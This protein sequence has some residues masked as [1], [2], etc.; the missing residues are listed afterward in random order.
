[1]DPEK[2]K[3]VELRTELSQRGLDTKGVKSVLVERLRKALQEEN[4]SQDEGKAN[5]FAENTHDVTSQENDERS[6]ESAKVPQTPKKSSRLSK[7]A[8]PVTP[9]ETPGAKKRRTSRVTYS[10]KRTSPKKSD[11]NDRSQP[12]LQEEP[13]IL[14]EGTGQEDIASQEEKSE[15]LERIK[16]AET[17]EPLQNVKNESSDAMKITKDEDETKDR[18]SK[19]GVAQVFNAKSPVKSNDKENLS[20]KKLEEKVDYKDQPQEPIQVAETEENLESTEVLSDNKLSETDI[21]K[22]DEPSTFKEEEN[23]MED[24]KEESLENDK[25]MVEAPD[26]VQIVEPVSDIKTSDIPQTQEPTDDLLEQEQN[27]D[28]NENDEAKPEDSSMEDQ[29]ILSGNE[30]AVDD[31]IDDKQNE[32][33]VEMTELKVEED[34]DVEL[35]EQ[36]K[37]EAIKDRKRKRS[38]S[39]MEDREDSPAV[40]LIENEPE[41]DDAALILSWYDSDLNLVIDKEGFFTATPMHNDGFS[42]MWAGARAS[43]GFLRGKVYYEAK[44]VDLCP[45]DRENE[46]YPHILRI[47]WS[48]PYTSM[49]LG[50]DKFSFG[51]SSS[52]KKLTDNQFEDYGLQFGKDDV[53]GC[54]FDATSENSIVLSYTINGKDQGTAFNI[55]KEELGEKSLFPHVLSKNCSFSCNFG[56]EKPWAEEVLDD[57]TSIGQIDSQHKIPGPRRP[58]KKE[59][60]EV[61]MMCGLPG[62]GKTT[63]AIKH[64]AEQPH[65]M[66]NI[67]GLGSLIDKIKDSDLSHKENNNDQW[68][69][70]IDKCTRVLDKLL[71]I[72][73]TRRRNY[74][75]DQ[76]NVYPS[77]Q[78][79]KMKNFSGYQRKAMV[80]VPSE[81]EFKSRVAKHKPIEGKEP[82]ESVLMEMKASFRAPVVGEHFDVVE[83]IELSQEDGEKLIIKYL[84]EAKEAGY[85]QQQASKRPRFDSR[86]ENARENRNNARSNRDNRDS[87]DYRD[88]RGNNYSERNRNPGWRGGGG[89]GGGGN[90]GWRDRPQR[91]GHRHGGGYGPPVS[92][93]GGRGAPIPLVHRG[94]D[95]RGGTVDRRM[96]NDRGRAVGS[97]QG[98]WA[99]MGNYAGSQQSA[100]NQQ[101][102]W[103][104]GQGT[105]WGQQNNWGS[106]QWGSWKS[107][108]QSSYS[109]NNYTQQGY[110]N[111]NWNSWNQQYYNQYWGQQQQ[112]QQQQQQ[113]GSLTNT[114]GDQTVNKQ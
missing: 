8:A 107:Y 79:R 24:T 25:E 10:R 65:K 18:E 53:I 5:T 3:V 78:R 4:A 108:G 88:R 27:T 37:N 57:Y 32:Q 26:D 97:R 111:G 59:E 114:S 22:N 68:E 82:A 74:I 73:P 89:G 81:E 113:Q 44:I 9:R 84:K 46:E 13:T 58:D 91:G 21:V 56:Q 76:T 110:G 67:L 62:C 72:A 49:Q 42:H 17:E 61:I 66:Y 28:E 39:P 104:S 2:L 29:N 85:G 45:A 6:S 48:T 109:Q 77:A 11:Q 35:K 15:S 19:A 16:E 102:N 86:P 30:K 7:N 70:L 54:Y 83:W 40:E 33:D 41:I 98:G 12:A 36:G 51:Y 90:M 63:W 1:M 80:L 95:R 101:G 14:E 43:Y 112:P 93:R 60:C 20:V 94:M 31:I 106:Q 50:E 34:T 99:P 47:G 71:E 96:G 64:A 92:W 38:P 52:G 23:R 105:A 69:V 87:R 75:L 103:S 55:S 100:W